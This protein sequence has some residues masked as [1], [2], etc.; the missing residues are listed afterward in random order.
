MEIGS[1]NQVERRPDMPTSLMTR[2]SGKP[3]RSEGD[4]VDI[5][6]ESRRKLAELADSKRE[7]NDSLVKSRDRIDAIR[8]RVEAGYYRQA[9]IQRSIADRLIDDL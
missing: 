4:S 1:V 8:Q 5:S 7:D 2:P 3:S 6:L 9:D